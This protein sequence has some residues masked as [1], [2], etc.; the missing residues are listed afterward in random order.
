MTADFMRPE[1]VCTRVQER[2]LQ[3]TQGFISGRW[4]PSGKELLFTLRKL[5]VTVS[6]GHALASASREFRTRAGAGF[7]IGLEA[8]ANRCGQR[9]LGF[10]P[11]NSAAP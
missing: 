5:G 3:Y 9:A 7:Q 10:S 1:G 2:G 8:Y 4:L 11:S 6:S